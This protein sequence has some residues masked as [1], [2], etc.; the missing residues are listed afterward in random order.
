VSP[1]PR[2]SAAH[3]AL[4]T[5]AARPGTRARW[6]LLAPLAAA[7]S[8]VLAQP[9]GAPYPTRPIRLIVPLP[10]GGP[11]DILARLVA[12]PLQERLG[13]P[14]VVDNRPGASGN[15]GA[16]IAAKAAPDGHTLFAGTSGPLANN[17]S[18]YAKLPYDPVR[19]FAPIALVA[20]APFVL[21]VHPSLPVTS[22]K[23]FI[24]YAKARPGK[25]NY[26]AVPGAAAHL[27]SEMFRMAS[28]IDAVHVPY[29]GAGPATTDVIAGQIQ[30]T[31][32]STPG[33]IPHVKAG[34]LRALAV[35]SPK[36]V[37]GAPDLPTVAEGGGPAMSAQVWYGVVAPARTPRE[38]VQRLYA[39][40]DQIVKQPAMRERMQQNDFEPALMDPAAFGAF[41]RSEIAT[42]AKVVKA[43]GIK[44]D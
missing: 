44:A 17:V 21:A 36:R 23:E 8:G 16:E 13:Q 35:T 7:A 30:F 18:L 20:T 33:A 6:L 41:I 27:A 32:A 15:I 40:I 43:A 22:V 39:E 42:W 38:I 28:G 31:F 19:D 12:T 1:L 14:V 34:K 37:S 10:A 24:A 25:L 29:K 2:A 9:A 4:A 26:G 11:T 3:D 5:L